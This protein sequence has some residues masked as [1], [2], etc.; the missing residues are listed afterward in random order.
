MKLN[1][2]GDFEELYHYCWK[3]LVV[4]PL[5]V[6][7]GWRSSS[8]EIAVGYASFEDQTIPNS[9]T[10]RCYQSQR[11]REI[12][13]SAVVHQRILAGAPN[14]G[15]QLHS[16][17]L[18]LSRVLLDAI[19]ITMLKLEIEQVAGIAQLGERQTE[20]LKVA[21]SIHAHRIIFF[22]IYLSLKLHFRPYLTLITFNFLWN[23]KFT[24]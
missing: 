17:P 8:W 20:D 23:H 1:G 22:P 12:W 19:T 13:T 6:L 16:S 15:A 21:C 18:A 3:L 11:R 10:Y 7:W 14:L 24:L 4:I 2:F 9:P 5:V